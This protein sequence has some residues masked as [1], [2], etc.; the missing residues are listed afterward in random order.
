MLRPDLDALEHSL[1]TQTHSRVAHSAQLTSRLTLPLLGMHAHTRAFPPR[2]SQ[3]TPTDDR[4]RSRPCRLHA[5]AAATR[6]SASS[7]GWAADA[8]HASLV[9]LSAIGFLLAW[10]LAVRAVV[11]LVA[12]LAALVARAPFQA[13]FRVW[14]VLSEIYF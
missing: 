13:T 3:S 1:R 11:S 7:A 5:G 12:V 14:E 4:C 6:G 10:L 2:F 9:V 8:A